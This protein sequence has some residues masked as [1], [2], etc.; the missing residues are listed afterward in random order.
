MKTKTAQQ[1][2]KDWRKKIILV[3][4][5][6]DDYEAASRRLLAAVM[7]SSQTLSCIYLTTG[8]PHKT[9][10]A[11]LAKE[12]LGSSRFFF[13][14]AVSEP[15]DNLPANVDCLGASKGLTQMGIAISNAIFR[16][17]GERILFIDS[18]SSLL[19]YNPPDIILRFM[20]SMAGKI[21]SNEISGIM[22]CL[23]KDYGDVAT[24]LASFV[25]EVVQLK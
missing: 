20:H 18:I 22:L 25:D 17:K 11:G 5:D 8:K 16:F 23:P 6:S 7:R 1:I 13:I 9:I 15:C 10:E 4:V 14:D 21:R 2:A 3:M 12:R 24:R 19:L